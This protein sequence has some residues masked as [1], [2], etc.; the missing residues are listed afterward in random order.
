MAEDDSQLV[1]ITAFG[2]RFEDYPAGLAENLITLEKEGAIYAH[3]ADR[4]KGPDE[5]DNWS[6]RYYRIPFLPPEIFEYVEAS[7]AY[8]E[9]RMQPPQ[10]P[11]SKRPSPQ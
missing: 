1:D 2:H 10:T 6:F 5:D 11:A 3:F 8:Q 4:E 9:F 7:L